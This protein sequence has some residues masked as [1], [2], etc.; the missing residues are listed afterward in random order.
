M[1]DL[2]II[3]TKI[4]ERRLAQNLRM[5]DLADKA[6]ISRAT[7]WSIEKGM[8]KCSLSSLLNVLSVLNLSLTING[9]INSSHRN[10]AGRINTSFD[11]KINRFVIMCVEQYA[12]YINQCSNETY[13]QM[14]SSG[15]IQELINDYEDLHGMSTLY[16]NEYIDSLIKGDKQ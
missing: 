1:D 8:G 6:N 4:K 13:K 3:G 2:L 5:D 9:D 7:L 15:A 11:K 10:R 12:N 16:L 14:K